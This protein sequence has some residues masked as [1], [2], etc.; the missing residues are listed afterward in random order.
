MPN[1]SRKARGSA[2]PFRLIVFGH[3]SRN[4]RLGA[5][6]DALAQIRERGQLRLDV[7]GQLWNQKEVSDRVN[8][9]GLGELVTLHGYVS[10]SELDEALARAQLAVNLRYPTMG[11][12]SLTQLQ[13]WEARAAVAR[14]AADGYKNSPAGR[15][16]SCDRGA[17]SRTSKDTCARSSPTAALCRDGENGRRALEEF[18]AP[19]LTHG[20]H[21]FRRR[22]REPANALGGLRPGGARRAEL[23]AWI[24]PAVAERTV[25][26][27]R[28]EIRALSAIQRLRWPPSGEKSFRRDRRKLQHWN[29][30]ITLTRGLR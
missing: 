1:G 15:S 20:P 5:L 13:I 28:E 12:A 18:H 30:C 4:R 7:Y 21:E 27:R 19:N 9:L 11:E 26:A 25:P 3:L 23:G 22:S 14:D 29:R 2:P 6:L 8:A 24:E 17:K 10:E 16:P